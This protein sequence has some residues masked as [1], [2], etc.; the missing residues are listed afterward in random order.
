MHRTRQ[1]AAPGMD[2]VTAAAYADHLEANRT[3][4]HARLRS[5][6]DTAPPGQRT[7]LDKADGRQRPIGMPAFEDKIAQRAVTQLWSV[8]RKLA[9]KHG[10]SYAPEYGER[11]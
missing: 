4:L 6:R 5:G 7:W 11:L 2:G 3:D 10:G 9:S 1:E 8:R